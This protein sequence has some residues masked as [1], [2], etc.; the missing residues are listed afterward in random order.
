M[1]NKKIEILSLSIIIKIL[2]FDEIKTFDINQINQTQKSKTLDDNIN[3]TN[4]IDNNKTRKLQSTNY[5]PIRIYIDTYYLN[6][7]TTAG[8][9][10]LY[11]ESLFRAKNTLEKLIKVK[12]EPNVINKAEYQ[13]II[14]KNFG[15]VNFNPEISLD[16]IDL[17]IFVQ[18][19]TMDDNFTN[20][21]CNEFP[22]IHKTRN[23]RPII[24]SIIIDD[25]L[26]SDIDRSNDE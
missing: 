9:F 1:I 17:A 8:K 23:G 4:P 3:V 24:G 20:Y 14:K 10:R 18:I 7:H 13:E 5:E 11:N 21:D 22:Q 6:G 25:G 26:Y 19:S 2:L 16:E 15:E 12:R